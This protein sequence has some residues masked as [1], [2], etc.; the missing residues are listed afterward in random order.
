MVAGC[1][2]FCPRSSVTSPFTTVNPL[3]GS[4]THTRAK[5]NVNLSSG[6]EIMRK[7]NAW[8]TKKKE[9]EGRGGKEKD[10][11]EKMHVT[12]YMF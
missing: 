6:Y 8:K 9:G 3:P 2:G 12:M 7:D 5:Q 11:G 1:C 10:K 4:G